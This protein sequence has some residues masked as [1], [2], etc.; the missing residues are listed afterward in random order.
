M[1]RM[2]LDGTGLRRREFGS[3]LGGITKM[4]EVT[5]WWHYLTS[6][7]FRGNGFNRAISRVPITIWDFRSNW[8]LLIM[9]NLRL[10]ASLE[11]LHLKSNK[12]RK[13]AVMLF[14]CSFPAQDSK[15]KIP[16][17]ARL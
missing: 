7:C 10:R 14:K 6:G 5:I 16:C 11:V 1:G 3:R 8:L 13:R 4:N 12:V 9:G 17:L 15:Y 2:L